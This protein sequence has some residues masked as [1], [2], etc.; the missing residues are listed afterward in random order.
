MSHRSHGCAGERSRN[1]KTLTGRFKPNA[2]NPITNTQ[3]STVFGRGFSVA[4]SAAGE[5]TLTIS[6]VYGLLLHVDAT[7]WSSTITDAGVFRVKSVTYGTST[8]TIVL[9]HQD[10]SAGAMAAADIAAAAD[11]FVSFRL[12]FQDAKVLNA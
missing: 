9:V 7:L 11:N 4:R 6:D 12:V 5:F 1:C 2:G 3:G 10:E 8:T